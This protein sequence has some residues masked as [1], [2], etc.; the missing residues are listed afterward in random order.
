MYKGDN[1]PM[2]IRDN[3]PRVC[4]LVLSGLPGCGKSSLARLLKASSV[5]D[6]SHPCPNTHQEDTPSPW[7]PHTNLH[8]S[9][10]PPEREV[11]H[12][13]QSTRI[14][15][16]SYDELIPE[17]LEVQMIQS[18]VDSEWKSLREK[19]VNCVECLVECLLS[20]NRLRDQEKPVDDEALW[21]RFSQVVETQDCSDFRGENS[22][23]CVLV[24]DDNMYYR[25]M[26][27]KYFQLAR[28]YE[29]GFCQIHLQ[30]NKE[31][32]MTRNSTRTERRVPNDVIITMATKMEMP[33]P[34]ECP[35]EQHSVILDTS[36]IN[37]SLLHVFHQLVQSAMLDPPRLVLEDVEGKEESRHICSANQLHQA[38]QILRRLVSSRIKCTGTDVSQQERSRFAK[39]CSTLKSQ[40]L[41]ELR[42]GSILVPTDIST[43]DASKMED[44]R[45]YK[46][47]EAT[48]IA[49]INGY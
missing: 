19:I 37:Q 17:D 24:I 14:F 49:R 16:V 9:T 41:R 31:L 45:F 23:P 21:S 32:A 48:F 22:R 43:V 47:I 5:P 15:H 4:I 11:T 18:D 2:S 6:T 12:D 26:R 46:Y 28:K 3:S 13:Q 7:Q 44:C 42:T 25:S 30:C 29:Q 1:S 27:H 20:S 39:F 36:T 38:D 33:N 35:W 10:Q 40:I 34:Q 8:P